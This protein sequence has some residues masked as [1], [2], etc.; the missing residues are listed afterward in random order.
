[1][2]KAFFIFAAVFAFVICGCKKNISEP[3]TVVSLGTICVINLY[4][5][6]T[7]ENYREV[8]NLLRDIDDKFSVNKEDS[9]ISK[10][11]QG[12]GTGRGVP[13][14]KEV[15]E[16]VAQSLE[17][18][19]LTRNSFNPA[20]GT[21][22]KM[23]G[24]GTDHQ[25]VPG[26]EEISE[27]LEHCNPDAVLFIEVPG[28]EESENLYM[29]EITDSKTQLDLGAIVKGYAAD[30][31]VE[32]LKER[33]VKKA[34]VNLGGNI[35]VFGQ[36]SK[37]NPDEMW[38]VGIKNPVD[39]EA[40]VIETVSLKSGSVVTSGNYERFF[41]ENGKRYHHI[42]DSKTGYPAE[43]GLSSVTVIYEKSIVCD[44]LATAC[45]VSGVNGDF[46]PYNL[47]FDGIKIVFVDF[48]GKPVL[49]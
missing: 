12:A 30:R 32:V 27:A 19:R 47:G 23:W 41:E 16:V 31:I 44:A 45:Y 39:T 11:N 35:Y 2:K 34:I 4:E 25:R 17:F 13:V 26:K 8:I 7:Y 14:S 37:L 6:G 3:Q 46:D 24:I 18:A 48:N 29:I 38:K 28:F 9:E 33:N 42:L 1:M 40:G 15:Y 36:K 10:V 21:L 43:S 20:M 49:K 22:I 5:D